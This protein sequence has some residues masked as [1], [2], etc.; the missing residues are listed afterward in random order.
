MTT[1]ELEHDG[2]RTPLR[3]AGPP[4]IG[5]PMRPVGAAVEP[6]LAARDPQE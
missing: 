3:C 1:R 6:T 2:V 4:T 5:R